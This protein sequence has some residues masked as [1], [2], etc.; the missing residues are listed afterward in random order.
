M[1]AVVV[2]YARHFVEYDE[3]CETMEEAVEFITG[4]EDAGNIY[5]IS[6]AR[7]GVML[8]DHLSPFEPWRAL[9]NEPIPIGLR[10]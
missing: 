5:A 9:T 4:Q 3:E 10:S 6:I 2:H 8:A 1:T 7:D